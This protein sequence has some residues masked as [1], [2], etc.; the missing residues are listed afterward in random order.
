MVDQAGRI[1]AFIHEW[2][3]SLGWHTQLTPLFFPGILFH[4]LSRAPWY[5]ARQ[6]AYTFLPVMKRCW[7]RNICC[8]RGLSGFAVCS[9]FSSLKSSLKILKIMTSSILLF[10]TSSST[11]WIL[12][13]SLVF[14]TFP[15]HSLF[16]FVLLI[17]MRKKFT[18][19]ENQSFT[20][21][22]YSLR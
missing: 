15:V 12:P 16:F 20:G 5:F 3:L 13:K 7:G 18:V 14:W 8:L 22:I 10:G 1:R 4:L 9:S 19:F 21:E 2:G 17:V 11:L 6:W